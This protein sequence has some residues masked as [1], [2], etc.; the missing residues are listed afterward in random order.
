MYLIILNL[1]A[2]GLA[3]LCN[4]VAIIYSFSSFVGM[5]MN[6]RKILIFVSLFSISTA[7][8]AAP[9]KQKRSVQNSVQ[10]TAADFVKNHWKTAAAIYG[11]KEGSKFIGFI[12]DYNVETHDKEQVNLK[13]IFKFRGINIGPKLGS[14][15][16]RYLPDVYT[17]IQ[18]KLEW[19]AC[20][21]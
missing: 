19:I 9:K 6:N 1:N 17:Y 3:A 16:G 11:I 4:R 14:A 2:R 15:L 13:R 20:L 5:F 12:A 21:V 10:N 8:C 18:P 7:L